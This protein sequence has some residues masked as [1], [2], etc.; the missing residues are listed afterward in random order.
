MKK[1]SSTVRISIKN[2]LAI[3]LILSLFHT[4]ISTLYLVAG[5]E[6]EFWGMIFVVSLSISVVIM[7]AM[8]T[9]LIVD[10]ESKIITSKGFFKTKR[11][12]FDKIKTVEI[13]KAFLGKAV[14]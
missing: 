4:L 11:L 10:T 1:N 3:F 7:L 13:K 6:I 14:V 12:P 2:D 5:W 9:C 8:R